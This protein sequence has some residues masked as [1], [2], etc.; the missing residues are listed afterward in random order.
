MLVSYCKVGTSQLFRDSS[1]I[2]LQLQSY[3]PKVMA[4]PTRRKE[5]A[6]VTSELQRMTVDRLREK[7]RAAKLSATGTK[8]TLTDRLAAHLSKS[9]P[10]SSHPRRSQRQSASSRDHQQDDNNPSQSNQHSSNGDHQRDSPGTSSSQ[11]RQVRY[12]LSRQRDSPINSSLSPGQHRH[13][14][15]HVSRH[16]HGRRHVSRQRDSHSSHSRS[17]DTCSEDRQHDQHARFRSRSARRRSSSADEESSGHFS[18]WRSLAHLHAH[19]Y[20]S[21]SSRKRKHYHKKRSRSSSS[22]SSDTSTS[23]STTTSDSSEQ[24]SPRKKHHRHHHRHHKRRKAEV[25]TSMRTKLKK[26]SVSCYPPLPDRYA[27]RIA[28]EQTSPPDSARHHTHNSGNR[29]L[30]PL[31]YTPWLCKRG[32]MQ[33]QAHLQQERL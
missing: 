8:K 20:R 16:R 31:Q 7:L 28:K 27:A 12:R 30:H 5:A 2:A 26:L 11:H 19:H 1:S 24:P 4:P 22:S 25:S 6:G 13:G 32:H 14:R 9:G 33:V 17:R 15:H 18:P 3:H 29:N 21:K 10:S 23:S